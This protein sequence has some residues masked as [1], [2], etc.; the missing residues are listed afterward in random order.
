VNSA[1]YFI[2]EEGGGLPGPFNTR[3]ADAVREAREGG[4]FTELPIAR[5][6]PDGG[7]AHVLAN[8]SPNRLTSTSAFLAAGMDQIPDC[9]VTFAGKL[10]LTGLA[11]QRTADSLEVQY[12]WRCL[13]PLDRAY[14]CFTHIVD[15]KGAIAGYLDHAILNGEPPTSQWRE[16]DTGIERLSF[17]L[18]GT[19][20]GE[21][22][23]LRLGVFDRA[24][25]KRLP[26]TTSDFPL[27]DGGTATVVSE[28]QVVR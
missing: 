11:T 22:R 12:R 25:G 9:N 8:A 24:S 17:R 15:G 28:G 16:G 19:Q 10:Q 3:A 6:L 26:I 14:W 7:V 20:K 18:S 2:Y 23:H 1:A 4:K 13:K 27:T 5:K 21:P